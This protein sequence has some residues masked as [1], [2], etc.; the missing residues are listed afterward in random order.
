MTVYRRYFK[1]TTGPLIDEL[2][3]VWAVNES[4]R[5]EYTQILEDIGAKTSQWYGRDNRVTGIIF[6]SEPDITLFKKLDCG[7]WPKKNTKAGKALAARFAAVKTRT[8]ESAL[9]VVGI[10]NTA[11]VLLDGRHAYSISVTTI[12]EE[13]PVAY[14]SVPWRDEDPA[15]LARYVASEIEGDSFFHC[16]ELSFLTTFQPTPDMVEVKEWEVSKHVDEWNASV[17]EKNK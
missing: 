8:E 9:H 16:K 7:W 12:P 11:F 2:K 1:V 3:K 15:K 5:K 10:K 13:N 4:A 6:E 14:I 17:R